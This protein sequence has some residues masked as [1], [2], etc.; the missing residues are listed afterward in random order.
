[1]TPK[2]LYRAAAATLLACATLFPAPTLLAG[3]RFDTEEITVDP[4]PPRWRAPQQARTLVATM[5][6]STP[7]PN[8]YRLGAAGALIVDNQAYLIDAGEGALRAIAKTATAHDKALVDVFA[9]PKLTHLF[10]THLHSDHTVG[11]PSLILNP[12]IFGRSAPLEVYG[13]VGTQRLVDGI[14]AAYQPDIRERIDGPEGANDTGWRVNVHE[15]ESGGVVFQDERLKVE[16]FAH[17]HGTLPAYGYRFTSADRVVVWAGDGKAGPAFQEAAKDAGLLVTEIGSE[18]TVRNSP[19]GGM[20]AEERE[21]VVWSYHLKPSNLARLASAAKVKT[22]VLIH[23]SNYSAPYD[24]LA[25]LEEF[26]RLYSGEV[27][28]SRDADI[29]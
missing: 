19:W 2:R 18:A 29:Y 15:F 7:S 6:T 13:P 22:L 23:E 27:Y 25:I 12:W 16:A 4:G 5:G 20:S 3:N 28:S 17:E 24:P 1:M 14:L 9:P 10:L 21:R 8:P 26:R 11:L